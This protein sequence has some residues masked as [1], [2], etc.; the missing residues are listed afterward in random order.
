MQQP[1]PVQQDNQ[2]DSNKLSS[3][4]LNAF[5]QYQNALSNAI[6]NHNLDFGD[7]NM[8]PLN[9]SEAINHLA[10]DMY[11]HPDVVIE[12]QF[13]LAKNYIKLWNNVTQRLLGN[14]DAPLF[15]NE[16]RDNR[17]KDE[18]WEKSPALDFIKQAYFLNMKHVQGIFKQASQLDVKDQQKLEFISKQVFDALAPSNFGF[19]NPEVIKETLLTNGENL[20][21]GAENFAKDLSNSHGNLKI[22]TTDFSAFKLGE[23]VAITPGKVVYENDLMQLIQYTPKTDKVFA[24]PILIIAAWINKYY[25]LDL[26]PQN[27]LVNWLVEQG[28]TVFM[29]SW[30]NPSDKHS[31]KKFEDYMQE[32]P[33]AAI[34]VIKEITKQPQVNAVGYCL[35]GTLLSCTLA[36]L[37]AT[38]KAAEYPIKSATFLA[39]LVDFKNSGDICIF[40]DEEQIS[41]LEK[42][43]SEKGYL[44]GDAMAQT[45]S[46]IRATI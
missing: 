31:N 21:K 41:A 45:F 12:K 25:I 4:I 20:L 10:E 34:K 8:D 37:K 23:N 9:A 28:H 39:S 42:R 16:G 2:F 17:F 15:T 30:V 38:T 19:I 3:N 35:G 29:I 33:L 13:E 43:M 26:Q 46:M 1:I 40:I 24:V 36:Y 5:L 6:A 22:S 18:A 32:G 44:E 7:M 27:S 14:Q 11:A